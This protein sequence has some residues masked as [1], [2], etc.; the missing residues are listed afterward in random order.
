M[1]F[2]R[3]AFVVLLW[4]GF[5]AGFSYA[6]LALGSTAT[7]LAVIPVM[8]TA[9]LWKRRGGVGA[10]IVASI[11]SIG[12]L[13]YKNDESF[14]FLETS[15]LSRIVDFSFYFL[16]GLSVGWVSHLNSELKKYK[17]K[18]KKAQYDPL[19]KLLNRSSFVSILKNI[20]SKAQLSNT[21]AAVLFVDL[22]KFKQVNDTYGHDVGDEL[23]K[24]VANILRSSVRQGDHVG[25]LGGDEF[26]IAIS[27]IKSTKVAEVVAEKIVKALNSPFMIMSKEINISGSVGIGIYPDDGVKPEEL[28]KIADAS[29]YTVKQSG[30][31]NY[32]VKGEQLKADAEKRS[33]FERLLQYGFDNNEFELYYQP[34]I[35]YKNKTLRGFEVLMRWRNE[36]LGIVKPDEILPVAKSLGLLLVLDRWVL[37]EATYQLAS[38]FR[39]GF[40]PVKIA[41]NVS[42]IQFRNADFVKNIATAINDFDLNPEWLEFEVTEAA[43]LDDLGFAIE[44]LNE[45]SA[46]GVGLVLD[47]LGGGYLPIK[48]LQDMP[49]SIYKTD[50]DLL[51]ITSSDS[52]ELVLIEAMAYLSKKLGKKIM[53]S[54]VETKYQHSLVE[55]LNCEYGQGFLYSR[56]LDAKKAQKYLKRPQ[57][58]EKVERVVQEAI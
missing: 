53:I 34:Q 28:I 20:M 52:K 49:I 38:W 18:T 46:L 6:Y 25:R 13:F 30:K 4:L 23:L 36:E 39:K 3:V 37:R 5:L 10:A 2:W 45:L 12:M 57:N 11:L 40:K 15:I 50:R 17:T 9:S 31:N 29:M 14:R 33:R 27:D 43:L 16:A 1:K 51:K 19:T 22:D 41:I 24:Q 56:P 21:K 55:K 47:G 58:I 32:S 35:E 42:E 44:V 26:L 54:G 8:F 48:A 7:L